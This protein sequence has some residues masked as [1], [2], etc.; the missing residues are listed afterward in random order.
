MWRVLRLMDSA[1][2]V[3]GCHLTQQTRVQNGF[4]DV[5]STIHQSLGAGVA[6]RP[7]HPACQARGRAAQDD[8]KLTMG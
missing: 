4:D 2:H 7:R 6:H 8:P 5:A 3:V 1:R